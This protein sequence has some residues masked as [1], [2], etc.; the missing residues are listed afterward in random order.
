MSPPV[1]LVHK[2]ATVH[3]QCTAASNQVNITVFICTCSYKLNK[4]LQ[5][6]FIHILAYSALTLLVGVKTARDI[7]PHGPRLT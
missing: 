7:L 6:V 4:L 5:F 2:M 1:G 3:M